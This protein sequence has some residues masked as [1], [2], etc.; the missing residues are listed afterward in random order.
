M[1]IK[2]VAQVGD[3]WEFKG[4]HR[5]M[6]G[7]CTNKDH[8]AKLIGND[9]F[10]LLF[11]SPPYNNQRIYKGQVGNIDFTKLMCDFSNA[12]IPYS[13]QSHWI[14]NLGTIRHKKAYQ[15]YYLDW[16]KHM[17]SIGHP[18]FECMIWDKHISRPGKWANALPNGHELLFQFVFA[19][20]ELNY[21]EP[22]KTRA[23]TKQWYLTRNKDHS[24]YKKRKLAPQRDKQKARSIISVS[25]TG[26]YFQRDF[27]QHCIEHGAR[28]TPELP[29]KIAS[30]WTQ[31][32]DIVFDPFA[33]VANTMIGC[34]NIN[35]KFI[36]M[37]LSTY[38]VDLVLSQWLK[39]FNTD[40]VNLINY[41]WYSDCL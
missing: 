5:L 20:I 37:E 28:F 7:D 15:F 38:Y 21:T 27:M 17:E 40:A 24:F 26:T 18:L 30:I 3:I 29:E 12:V 10:K 4:K 2:A 34:D 1:E 39:F 13:D 31:E 41:Q 11:T 25:A 22:I 16:L 9:K 33:G 14:V 32:N 23:N 19:D 8:I 36:G 6:C 35:R